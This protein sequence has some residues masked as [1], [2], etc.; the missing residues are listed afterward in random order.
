MEVYRYVL[1]AVV[2]GLG[3]MVQGITGFGCAVLTLPILAF[4]FPIKLLIPVVIGVNVLQSAWIAIRDR[5]LVDK[6][7]GT[8][9]VL[10]ALV[11]LPLGFLFYRDLPA[12]ELKIALGMFVVAV[13][14]WNLAGGELKKPLPALAYYP[15]LFLGGFT[16]GALAAGGPPIIIYTARMVPDKTAFRATISLLWAVLN[17]AMVGIYTVSGTWTR[18]MVP[19]IAIAAAGAIV[20]TLLGLHLHDRIPQKPFRLGVFSVL[21]LAGLVLVK[22]LLG[23]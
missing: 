23:W 15:L 4:V 5:K 19:L 6:K 12:E 1:L 17:T 3:F 2:L 8:A 22:P 7:H 13:A 9:M 21:L 14:V 16:E 10:C 18:E 20:G 11:T